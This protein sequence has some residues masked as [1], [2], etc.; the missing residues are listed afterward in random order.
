MKN[1]ADA[2]GELENISPLESAQLDGGWRK[3]LKARRIARAIPRLTDRRSLPLSFAQE[4]LWLLERL[5]PGSP[6]YNRPLAL[7]L[8]G[9]LDEAALR[10][11]L[12]AIID[13]H[14]VLRTRFTIREGQPELVISP[15]MALDLRVIELSAT[16]PIE[17]EALARRLATEVSLRPFDLAHE[18]PL[19]A[20]LLRSGSDDH[21]LLL[22]FH[23]MVFDG[24][25]A[26]VFRGE[27]SSLY[28]KFQAGE[29]PVLPELAIQYA[30]FAHWQR[31]NLDEQARLNQ[32]KYWVSQ[33]SGSVPLD[34]PTDRPRP[35]V[36]THRG[37][38]V[39]LTLSEFLA[40]SLK[41]LGRQENATLFM[42]LLA[43][44]QSLLA[45][46]TGLEDVSVGA[47]V[48]GRNSVE[49]EN[50]IGV[51]INNLV[52]RSDLA[53][54]PT[55][56]QVLARV[57]ETCRGAYSHQDIPFAK[58]IEALRPERDLGTTPLFQVMFNLENLP[59][60]EIIIPGLRMEEFDFERPVAD[61]EL[62]LEVIPV[63]DRLRCFFAYNI[64]IF[65]RGTLERMAGHYRTLL[66][67]IVGEP[68]CR[69]ELLPLLPP[70]ERHQILVEWNR[71]EAYFPC[72]ATIHQLFEAQAARTP[73]AAAFISESGNL[74]YG[75][76]D[77]RSNQLAHYLRTQGVGPE[78]FVGVCLERSPE[79]VMVLL[80]A[81]KAGAAFVPLDPA[82]PP[83]R[84]AFM[85]NDAQ[86]PLVV[87][88][89]KW[90][91]VVQGKGARVICLDTD[92]RLIEAQEDDNLPSV[93]GTASVAYVLYT[94][95]S[96]G[97][98]K[99]VL[100]PHR[101]A[102]NRFAWMWKNFPFQAGEVSC[103]GTSLNFVDSIWEIFGPLLRGGPASSY[104]T[105]LFA[106]PVN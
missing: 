1:K 59:E 22:V 55:F 11:S 76:L 71:T 45:R 97:V 75:D 29:P 7:R 32:L 42:V 16:N 82:Y 5:E 53:G 47:P 50:L 8:T 62:T 78:S 80:A 91:P 65:D 44:F 90:L 2:P 14:E 35:S 43:A 24:W 12:Q 10:Q 61:Y 37:G 99:G 87:S 83:D 15:S 86:I 63:G 57:R 51:F 89:R 103:F 48:A 94:S 19:R 30:D 60:P 39:E 41:A 9:L 34:L 74:T 66:E 58:L 79:A 95:G 27:L 93:T 52:L 64:D 101:G 18:P 6:A 92:Q 102:V 98:P 49:T 23:H 26:R 20:T 38:C 73:E 56:R 105:K 17:R 28:R 40:N 3:K 96:S 69:L 70:A 54:N 36:Q 88:R 4:R 46:C 21:I 104:P 68:D 67:G 72:D 25:S 13:R 100:G 31:Q 33:L 106:T 85:I 81:L 84:L 77:R